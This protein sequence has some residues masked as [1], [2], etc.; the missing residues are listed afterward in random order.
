M[1]GGYFIFSAVSVLFGAITFFV[2]GIE[3]F[4]FQKGMLIYSVLFAFSYGLSMIFGFLAIANG[5][6]ALTSLFTS[7]S[8][9]IVVGEWNDIEY[10]RTEDGIKIKNKLEYITPMYILGK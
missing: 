10:E 3:N 1:Q 2:I 8:L 6:L 9:I 7:Y 5:S 4:H